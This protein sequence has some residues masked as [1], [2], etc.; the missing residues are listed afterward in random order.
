MKITAQPDLDPQAQLPTGPTHVASRCEPRA[1]PDNTDFWK[2]VRSYTSTSRG[3]SRRNVYRAVA[4]Y[5][6]LTDQRECYAAVASLSARAGLGTTATRTQL[7]ML[8]REGSLE[9]VGGRSGGRSKGTRYRL[10][11]PDENPTLSVG[12]NPTLSVAKERNRKRTIFPK[13]VHTDVQTGCEVQQ[14]PATD[15]QTFSQDPSSFPSK[16]ADN[17]KNFGPQT[18]LYAK[19]YR[20]LQTDRWPALTDTLLSQFDALDYGAKKQTLDTLLAQEETKA[21]KGEVTLPPSGMAS[22]AFIGGGGSV[23][24]VVADLRKA[25][26]KG[27][28]HTDAERHYQENCSHKYD[29]WGGCLLCGGQRRGGD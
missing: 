9:A 26:S 2:A 19:L 29:E 27:G 18:R 22:L 13:Y 3:S 4:F 10:V 25:L 11:L 8:E 17:G 23:K 7:R 1:L 28:R 21:A 5:V 16:A 24:N 15:T 12:L 14:P 6:S 20:K